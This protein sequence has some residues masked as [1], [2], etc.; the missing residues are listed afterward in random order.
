MP[1]PLSVDLREH[2]VMAVAKVASFQWAEA[3]YGVGV[4]RARRLSQRFAQDG[5]AAPKP[6]RRRQYVQPTVQHRHGLTL[7]S[8][9]CTLGDNN[10]CLDVPSSGNLV[11]DT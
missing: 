7:V 3:R 4:S 9:E 5:H 11:S 6:T 1:S 2:F 8:D 10:F